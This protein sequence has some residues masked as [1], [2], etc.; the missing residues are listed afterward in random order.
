MIKMNIGYFSS[1]FPYDT[2]NYPQYSYGGSVIATYHLALNIVKR[3]HNAKVFSTSANNRDLIEEHGD[4]EVYRYG[5]K[6]RFLTSCISSGLFYKPL[7]HNV[8]IVHVSFDIPPSPY[9]G[10]RYAKSQ[11]MPFVVTYHGDWDSSYGN[12]IRKIGISAS[13]K[14]IINKLLSYAQI[15][16]SPSE[17]YVNSSPYLTKY[18]KKVIV[19]PNGVDLDEFD[20]NL[21]K[22]ECKRILGLPEDKLI[23]LFF[24]FLSPYKGPNILLKSLPKILDSVPNALLLFA[25]RGVLKESLED[26]SEKM[27][28]KANVR[29]CGF[30]EER[31]KS[32]YYKSADIF[33]LPSMMS[34]ECYPL[35]ILEAMACSIPVIASNIGGIPD[36]IKDY[37][38]G[39]LVPPSDENALANAIIYLLQNKSERIRFATKARTFVKNYSWNSIAEKTEG[40]YETLL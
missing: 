24:G 17:S 21:T 2:L 28:V 37:Q 30:V 33:C 10:Y 11:N 34:T 12:I 14:F 36:I 19:I 23:I 26:L 9:A 20:S 31:L 18:N 3:G 6:F 5:T 4:L 13:N 7:M 32:L 1:K 38:T 22:D 27:S 35:A 39:I 25:G 40:L 29:F 8:D 15:I 16:I